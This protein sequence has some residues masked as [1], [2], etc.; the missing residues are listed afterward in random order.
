MRHWLETGQY[1]APAIPESGYRR[2]R[3]RKPDTHGH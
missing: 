2:S 3:K 1:T